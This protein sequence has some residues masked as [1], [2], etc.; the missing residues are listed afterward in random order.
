MTD[1]NASAGRGQQLPLTGVTVVAVEQAVAAPFATRQLA[2]LGARVIKIER[3]GTGDFARAYDRTVR[4][5]AS[6]F[7]WLN[8]SKES[9]T[10]D[11]KQREGR[12]VLHALIAR[13][14]VVV[15]NLA[16]GA[17][18]RAGF[19]SAALRRRHPSLICVNISGYGDSGPYRER[20]AYDLL[21]QAETGLASVTG[22]PEGPGRVGVS[23][24]DIA[25]GMYAYAA[26]L[27]ALMERGRTGVGRV[28][29][30][31]LFDAL[32]DWMAVPLLQYEGSGKSPKRVGLNHPS[33]APYGAYRCGDGESVLISIQNERE[34]RALCTEVLEKPELA[35]D[36]DALPHRTEHL[37][38]GGGYRSVVAVDLDP[39]RY[40]FYCAVVNHAPR[41]M[42]TVV[43]V[44]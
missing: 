18:A 26:I 12:D 8:R 25:C 21:L 11:I 1:G 31:S 34:W 9:L 38:L 20:R 24:C 33:I 23:V 6:Y 37:V 4:G 22:G 17:A 28:I 30:V 36:P 14:D 35:R 29:D 32:A 43:D 41:G 2:D 3:P 39:G 42:T 10:L 15:Q 19:G 13:A 40:R 16:P 44:E 5:Q 7:V 27:E